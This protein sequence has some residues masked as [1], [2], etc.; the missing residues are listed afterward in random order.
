M[1]LILRPADDEAAPHSLDKGSDFV[2]RR[3]AEVPLRIRECAGFCVLPM[4]RRRRIVLIKVQILC[5]DEARRRRRTV[6]TS[7]RFDDGRAEKTVHYLA[8]RIRFRS[9]ISPSKYVLAAR[10]RS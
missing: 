6:C 7:R 9:S 3:G 1:C 5:Q 8:G 2:S 10:L 4:T